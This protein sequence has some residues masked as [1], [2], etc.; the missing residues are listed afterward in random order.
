[1]RKSIV[2]MIVSII[3]ASDDGMPDTFLLPLIN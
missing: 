3:S 1:M 2:L